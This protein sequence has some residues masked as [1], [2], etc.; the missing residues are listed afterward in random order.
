MSAISNIV[1]KVLQISFD[2]AA[3]VHLVQQSKMHGTVNDIDISSA[4]TNDLMS[5]HILLFRTDSLKI[6]ANALIHNAALNYIKST[7]RLK[8]SLFYYFVIVCY[9]FISLTLFRILM[10]FLGL[11]LLTHL[12]LRFVFII[13]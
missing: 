7:N 11:Y 4:N 6:S 10:S 3:S 1:F 8:E 13:Y 2:H 9:I 5:T 12:P